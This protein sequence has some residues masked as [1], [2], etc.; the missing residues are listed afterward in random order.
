[1]AIIF[2]RRRRGTWEGVFIATWCS[3]WICRTWGGLGP[4]I[5]IFP[6]SKFVISPAD[7]RCYNK[8]CTNNSSRWLVLQEYPILSNLQ[9]CRPLGWRLRHSW[10]R[11]NFLVRPIQHDPGARTPHRLIYVSPFY[12]ACATAWSSTSGGTCLRRACVIS[13]ASSYGACCCT[14]SCGSNTYSANGTFCTNHV[15]T[16]P[17]CSDVGGDHLEECVY[18]HEDG[19]QVQNWAADRKV[20]DMDGS[21]QS[22]FFFDL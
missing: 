14:S 1:M 7:A 19:P 12:C 17:S 9:F 6:A 8:S 11:N 5:L 2:P 3:E 4:H 16:G 22:V 20:R 18:S 15:Q 13:R 21:S 10:R